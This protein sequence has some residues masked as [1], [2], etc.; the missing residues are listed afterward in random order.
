MIFKSLCILVLWTKVALH[1]LSD[2]L[3][4]LYLR[5]A[6]TTLDSMQQWYL[7]QSNTITVYFRGALIVLVSALLLFGRIPGVRCGWLLR[8][9]SSLSQTLICIQGRAVLPDSA[10]SAELIN[11]KLM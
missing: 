3:K 8:S 4:P 6:S 5:T 10:D 7:I 9:S 11:V 2:G 1:W